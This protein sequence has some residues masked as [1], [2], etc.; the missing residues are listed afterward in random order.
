MRNAILVL[1]ASTVLAMLAS[2]MTDKPTVH[3]QVSSLPVPSDDSPLAPVADRT[4]EVLDAVASLSNRLD[5]ILS[6][7]DQFEARISA[8]ESRTSVRSAG[9]TAACACE[10]CD[11]EPCTCG[12]VAA[13][14]LDQPLVQ[15]CENGVC[16]MVP[17]GSTSVSVASS[18]DDGTT[19][20]FPVLGAP[21]R[22]VGRVIGNIRENRQA[23]RSMRQ[24]RRAARL[25]CW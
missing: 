23:I 3:A 5:V 7:L 11:C 21:V 2:V 18:C 22:L 16:S 8:L 25:G 9:T 20:A 4:D 1:I 15:V 13:A 10:V 24:E 14:T 17:A 12:Q 19:A 6:T